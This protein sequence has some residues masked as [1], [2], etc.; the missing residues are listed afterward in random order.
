MQRIY[1][2]ITIQLSPLLLFLLQL[3]TAVLS[4]KK[5]WELL[6]LLPHLNYFLPYRLVAPSNFLYVILI[7]DVLP[8]PV[9]FRTS[10]GYILIFSSDSDS[11]ISNNQLTR[12]GLE[13]CP[14]Q[15]YPGES[16]A[17][18]WGCGSIW[19]CWLWYSY[20]TT[21]LNGTILLW[22]SFSQSTLLCRANLFNFKLWKLEGWFFIWHND[23]TPV[24]N[25]NH[26]RSSS[27]WGD[28]TR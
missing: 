15:H 25:I 24:W 21:V 7:S 5:T 1:S 3:L 17:S 2:L 6:P 11:E 19:I 23:V 13:S 26:Q 28:N 27:V 16:P 8:G 18:S 20:S 14:M 9:I 22:H 4:K 10:R 12:Q